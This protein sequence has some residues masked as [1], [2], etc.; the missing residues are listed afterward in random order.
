MKKTYTL[1]I[2]IHSV[3]FAFLFNALSAQTCTLSFDGSQNNL[4][5]ASGDV[6]CV[7][8]GET[9]SGKI[10]S[11]AQGAIIRID[12]LGVFNPSKLNQMAGTIENEGQATFGISINL[13]AGAQIING[14]EMVFEKSMNINGVAQIEN[15]NDATLRFDKTTS[16]QKTGASFVN[17][18]T[19]FFQQL[20]TGSG[21]SIINRARM[22]TEKLNLGNPFDNYGFLIAHD[23][24][25]INSGADLTNYCTFLLEGKCNNNASTTE[26]EGFIWLT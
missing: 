3:L 7:P 2:L 20:N 21:F 9:F 18:G 26:N 23:D 19:V 24:V 10:N 25:N 16:M 22:E 13:M 5:L 14:G 17:E 15:Q 12:S 1:G 6:F 11:V 4:N 8:A